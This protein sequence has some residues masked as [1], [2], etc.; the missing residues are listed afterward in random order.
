LFY[1]VLQN[2]TIFF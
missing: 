2:I 1:N